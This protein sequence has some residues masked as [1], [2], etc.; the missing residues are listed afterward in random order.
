M[1]DG[2][3][4]DPQPYLQ[5][6]F[7]FCEAQGRLTLNGASSM[8][9]ASAGAVAEVARTGVAQAAS[10]MAALAAMSAADAKSARVTSV[11]AIPVISDAAVT[12]V[13]ALY[14]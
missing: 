9:L 11:L 4:S 14:F 8:P 3:G 5:R 6:G 12:E 10:G 1:H 7:G 2:G 13:V